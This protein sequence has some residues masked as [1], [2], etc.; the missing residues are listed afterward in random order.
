MQLEQ[1]RVPVHFAFLILHRSQALLTLGAFRRF[2]VASVTEMA[3]DDGKMRF[4]CEDING[5]GSDTDAV[6]MDAF[7]WWV[8]SIYSEPSNDLD[9]LCGNP[10]IR[11]SQELYRDKERRTILL[12]SQVWGDFFPGVRGL[13]ATPHMLPGFQSRSVLLSKGSL[14]RPRFSRWLLNI[15]S[16]YIHSKACIL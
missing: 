3:G 13:R 14:F 12:S 6:G 1:G 8:S 4:R 9:C 7:R 10:K 5:D 11:D 15:S 16:K 2:S